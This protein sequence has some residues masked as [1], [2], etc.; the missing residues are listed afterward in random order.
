MSVCAPTV[1]SWNAISEPL[2][3]NPP[4]DLRS[5]KDK[6]LANDEFYWSDYLGELYL[7]STISA[8]RKYYTENGGT[9]SDLKLFVQETGLLDNNEKCDAL[10]RSL[11]R[12]RPVKVLRLTEYQQI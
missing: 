1:Q 8:A 2:D 6:N 7:G 11:I 12:M 5:G 4:Y 3:T 10:I 9:A